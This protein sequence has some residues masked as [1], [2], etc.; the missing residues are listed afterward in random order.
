MIGCKPYEPNLISLT[1]PKE[2]ED[3]PAIWQLVFDFIGLDL[4]YSAV[5]KDWNLIS[6]VP[7]ASEHVYKPSPR[8]NPNADT[9][10]I[11]SN[12]K[13]DIGEPKNSSLQKHK[14]VIERE[15]MVTFSPGSR[16][17]LE[18]KLIPEDSIKPALDNGDVI[19]PT[20]FKEICV[21]IGEDS[22]PSDDEARSEQS[23]SENQMRDTSC[24]V[25]T[26]NQTVS[27]EPVHTSTQ[28]KGDPVQHLPQ[29]SNNPLP[30]H[31]PSMSRNEILEGDSYSMS[32]NTLYSA[33]SN[34]VLDLK[35]YEN[36]DEQRQPVK[37][38]V[39]AQEILTTDAY[40][41]L[42]PSSHEEMPEDSFKEM[43]RHNKRIQKWSEM[44]FGARSKLHYNPTLKQQ[45]KNWLRVSKHRK[46]KARIRKG[47]PSEF[48]REVWIYISGSRE[49]RLAR[50]NIYHQYLASCNE[51]SFETQIRKDINRTYRQHVA[52]KEENS[53]MQQSLFNVLNTYA[54][55][56]SS[57]GYCQGM[58]SVAA[59]MLMYM[60]EVDVFWLLHS[61]TEGEKYRM[62][63]V[64]CPTMPD[65]NL[66]FFQF[67]HLLRHFM[68]KVAKHLEEQDIVSCSQYQ[69]SQWFITG[70]LATKIPTKILLRMWDIYLNEGIKASFRFGLAIIMHFQ[71]IILSSEMEE[72]ITTVSQRVNELKED[73]IDQ[74]MNIR[75]TRA[76]LK[77]AEKEFYRHNRRY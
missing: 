10:V 17:S 30:S 73:F 29:L 42:V 77:H 47:I 27:R 57:V 2:F 13:I 37:V 23:D 63:G 48:R 20:S 65:I 19:D 22:E 46:L 3:Y 41:F 64:W 31:S 24:S 54:L 72:I 26:E 15:R 28:T 76:M 11:T 43:T 55:Y 8:V 40:G 70:F 71:N 9:S 4:K 36:F 44:M 59:F 5:L 56:N 1:C 75:I 18:S 50:Q 21:L 49:Q 58:N 35:F 67:E 14:A 61:L 69:A 45:Y 39:D 74:A 32:C 16:G 51:S 38:E 6:K 66:R 33:T 34:S 60:E 25:I 62:K 7:L 68:P 53:A 12:Y 52:F